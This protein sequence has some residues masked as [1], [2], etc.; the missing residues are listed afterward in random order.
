MLAEIVNRLGER[1]VLLGAGSERPFADA[2]LPHLNL[3][4][5]DLVGACTLRES[6]AAASHLE[7]MV[8]PDSG[9]MHTCVAVG[10]R[11]VTTF[12]RTPHLQWGHDYAPHRVLIAP[13]GDMSRV[14]V[15]DVVSAVQGG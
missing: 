4:P 15:E 11:T 10:V 6:M 2:L 9:L 13:E 12:S 1:V 7:V 3:P 8:G 5:V 14:P